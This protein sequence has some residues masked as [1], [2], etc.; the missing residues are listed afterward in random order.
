MKVL[1]ILSVVLCI[2]SCIWSNA[3]DEDGIGLKDKILIFTTI[4]SVA[5]GFIAIALPFVGFIA[6]IIGVI[7]ILIFL[8][9]VFIRIF[10]NEE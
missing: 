2:I 8:G 6:T 7:N 3:V 5:L 1:I 10:L 4:C 9:I